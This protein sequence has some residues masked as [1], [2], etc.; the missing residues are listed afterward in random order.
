MFD[1]EKIDKNNK[2][3]ISLKQE[4]ITKIQNEKSRKELAEALKKDK[5]F[6]RKFLK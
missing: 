3:I 2:K 5:S 4:M 6:V 1:H